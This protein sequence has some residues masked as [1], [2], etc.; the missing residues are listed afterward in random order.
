MQPPLSLQHLEV[1]AICT[2]VHMHVQM[3]EINTAAQLIMGAIV[4]TS[5]IPVRFRLVQTSKKNSHTVLYS[6]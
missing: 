6:K 4:Q 2:E 3:H 5:S 1:L